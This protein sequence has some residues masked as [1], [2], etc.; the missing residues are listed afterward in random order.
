MLAYVWVFGILCEAAQSIKLCHTMYLNADSD[1]ERP[2]VENLERLTMN[3]AFVEKSGY[4][5]HVLID[6]HAAYSTDVLKRSSDMNGAVR[7]AESHGAIQ[8]RYHL[9][10]LRVQNTTFRGAEV[11]MDSKQTLDTFLMD[12][13]GKC[14]EAGSD[15]F[16]LQINTYGMSWHG[17]G[18]DEALGSGGMPLEDL[19]IVLSGALT[20]SK[21]QKLDMLGF[22]ASSMASFTVAKGF[23]YFA[24]YLLVSEATQPAHGWA[25]DWWSYDW[26]GMHPREYSS[27]IDLG[28]D[29]VN[30]FV[31]TTD[32]PLGHLGPKTLALLDLSKFAD[33]ERKFEAV[34]TLLNSA[35]LAGDAS[36]AKAISR[37]SSNVVRFVGTGDGRDSKGRPT[38]SAVDFGDLLDQLAGSCAVRG[39]SFFLQGANSLQS[40][41]AE[42]RAAYK[43]LILYSRV[44]L[45]S[46]PMSTGVH[47][48]LPTRQAA[49]DTAAKLEYN[50]MCSTESAA[51]QAAQDAN[52]KGCVGRYFDV[53]PRKLTT[54]MERWYPKDFVSKQV[55]P[56]CK[57][58]TTYNS[59]TVSG[60][61]V[62]YEA[63][64]VETE[65]ETVTNTTSETSDTMANT[66][67]TTT[68]TVIVALGSNGCYTYSMRRVQDGTMEVCGEESRLTFQV[69]VSP[70]V[71]H[72]EGSVNA[73]LRDP[74]SPGGVRVAN[75]HMLTSRFSSNLVASRFDGYFYTVGGTLVSVMQT[76]DDTSWMVAVDYFPPGVTP[77]IVSNTLANGAAAKE[78]YLFFTA[79]QGRLFSGLSLMVNK[80]AGEE[81]V[82]LYSEVTPSQKGTIVP[83]LY[84]SNGVRQEAAYG[85]GYDLTW[86]VT[87][88]PLGSARAI[89]ELALLDGAVGEMKMMLD[90]QLTVDT[91]CRA[92]AVYADLK[93]QQSCSLLNTTTSTTSTATSTT[94]TTTITTTTN[95]TITTMRTTTVTTV[96]VFNAYVWPKHDPNAEYTMTVIKGS[97]GMYV[98]NA[99]YFLLDT[100]AQTAVGVGI[101]NCIGLPPTY[102]KIAPRRA[103]ATSVQIDYSVKIPGNALPYYVQR[104]KEKALSLS[105]FQLE[106]CI[107]KELSSRKSTDFTVRILSRTVPVISYE[108]V[109]N[110]GGLASTNKK[111]GTTGGAWANTHAGFVC[112]YLILF[113]ISYSPF[114]A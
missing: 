14:I 103:D 112:M 90:T 57:T 109:G 31:D 78:G 106:T 61:P 8:Y 34:L 79:V 100:V 62:R 19:R 32:A 84:E 56:V 81:G 97:I 1:L 64:G 85:W 99:E 55:D 65:T 75:T 9:G 46:A 33:L 48:W 53:T 70:D 67:T 30:T 35:L 52:F 86:N 23:A 44:G 66:T 27:V 74:V 25:C 87:G 76:S 104:A 2:I 54:F 94:S 82:G 42:A 36:V 29:I 21:I 13:W 6:R 114:Q 47:L 102:M 107:Q 108:A 24:N 93:H 16:F 10:R 73:Y 110:T 105:A 72:V 28:T 12:A 3:R 80:N 60:E 88:F 18:R 50:Y 49:H 4:D 7:T 68:T 89:Q 41:L 38:Q 92:E 96:T 101:A 37:A 39:D 113:T 63:R 40:L 69:M 11:N 71:V 91:P 43:A 45:G 51:T 95:T 5:L 22:D 15:T 111:K 59:L 26:L 83:R 58:G 77:Q 17:T 20:A 98:P